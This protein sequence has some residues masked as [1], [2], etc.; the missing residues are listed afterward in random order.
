M[1]RHHNRQKAIRDNLVLLVHHARMV[2]AL[3]NGIDSDLDTGEL[4]AK[5][6]CHVAGAEALEPW[7]RPEC[8]NVIGE[9]STTKL[10]DACRQRRDEWR[11]KQARI[12]GAA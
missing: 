5:H 7:A 1:E 6:R 11:R 8:T 10:C 3:V 2:Y 9:R 12:E 4:A